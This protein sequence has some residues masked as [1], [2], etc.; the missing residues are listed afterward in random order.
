MDMLAY[1][2]TTVVARIRRDFDIGSEGE[3]DVMFVGQRVRWLL[4]RTSGRKRCICVD[5]ERNIEELE[6][7]QFDKS[8]KDEIQCDPKMHTNY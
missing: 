2:W 1:M 3:N 4:D 6:E 8:M 5:Q 7:V